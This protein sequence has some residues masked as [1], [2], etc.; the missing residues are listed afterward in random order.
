MVV[1]SY[2]GVMHYDVY[3]VCVSHSASVGVGV[4]TVL[5]VLGALEIPILQ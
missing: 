2:H 4:S 3:C 5:N 1:Y